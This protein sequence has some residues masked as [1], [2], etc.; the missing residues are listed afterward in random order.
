MKIAQYRYETGGGYVCIHPQSSEGVI[1]AIRVSEY[2]EIEFTPRPAAEIDAERR[3]VFMAEREKLKAR[4]A[5][6]E[7]QPL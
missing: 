1:N 5:A 7:V 6:L 3:Q 2:T 4:L